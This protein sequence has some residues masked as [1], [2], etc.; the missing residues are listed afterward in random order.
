LEACPAVTSGNTVRLFALL[1]DFRPEYNTDF[2]GPQLSGPAADIG[3]VQAALGA[4][5]T[6]VYAPSGSSATTTGDF[7]CLHP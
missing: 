4:D 2:G 3:I 5:R 1:T 6:P 7:R